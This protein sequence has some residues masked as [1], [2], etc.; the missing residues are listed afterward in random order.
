MDETFYSSQ[1]SNCFCY[2]LCPA[3]H[4][5]D[6]IWS[7][8][9]ANIWWMCRQLLVTNTW[10]STINMFISIPVLMP[11]R[12]QGSSCQSG[13]NKRTS[14]LI[15][16]VAFRKIMQ[17]AIIHITM[18][19]YFCSI[20]L[21]SF[22][23]EWRCFQKSY[24]LALSK[25]MKYCSDLPRTVTWRSCRKTSTSPSKPCADGHTRCSLCFF[26]GKSVYSTGNDPNPTD[27]RPSGG[28]VLTHFCHFISSVKSIRSDSQLS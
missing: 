12:L 6:F 19:S 23:N 9:L 18:S 7:K 1:L 5:T 11:V 4:I 28:E 2:I 17:L 26:K 20:L 24:D 13:G 25:Q 16:C 14:H 8:Q 3:W 15:L 10:G 21:N 22:Q 27:I